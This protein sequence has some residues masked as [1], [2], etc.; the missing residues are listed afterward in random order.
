MKT[1]TSHRNF[2]EFL[3]DQRLSPSRPDP[4][5]VAF[6][7]FPRMTQFSSL[8]LPVPTARNARYTVSKT[9]VGAPNLAASLT[10]SSHLAPLLATTPLAAPKLFSPS[11]TTRNKRN[12]P[13]TSLT[14]Y[15][16]WLKTSHPSLTLALLTTTLALPITTPSVTMRSLIPNF[17]PASS[18]SRPGGPP[19][20]LGAYRTWRALFFGSTFPATRR[21]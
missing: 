7:L 10:M 2:Q 11:L 13:A 19:I 5:P 20:Y 6:L 16:S 21:V 3:A 17:L 15:S 14:S 18:S 12:S 4:Q 8:T 9:V 1:P